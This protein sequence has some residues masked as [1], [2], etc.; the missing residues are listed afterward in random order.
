L[1]KTITAPTEYILPPKK[2]THPLWCLSIASGAGSMAFRYRSSALD[3]VADA[4]SRTEKSLGGYNNG[5]YLTRFFGQHRFLQTGLEHHTFW[6]KLDYQQVRDVQ[7]LK[8]N[9]LMAIVVNIHNPVDTLKRIYGDTLVTVREER[10][11]I[12]YNQYRQ[13]A[14]P[15]EFGLQHKRGRLVYGFTAGP[16]F[17][18]TTLQSGKVLNTSG[19]IVAFDSQH[20]AAPFQKFGLGLRGTVSVGCQV[21]PRWTILLRP[22]ADLQMNTKVDAQNLS[23]W[24][25]RFDVNLGI[26]YKIK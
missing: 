22:R 15:L 2:R 9:Q 23:G 8:K 17:Y 24:Y 14:L 12:H 20:Q 4:K 26:Q 7:V 18:L 21:A 16:A 5:I 6:S 3:S 11:V 25:R 13:W 1:H 10:T 19:Q